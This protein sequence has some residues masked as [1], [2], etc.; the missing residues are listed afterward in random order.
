MSLLLR[1][2]KILNTVLIGARVKSEPDGL[3]QWN[4]FIFSYMI[5]LLLV[6]V[7]VAGLFALFGV[8]QPFTAP[9]ATPA[10]QLVIATTN[11]VT[12]VLTYIASLS[13]H[14]NEAAIERLHAA[15]TKAEYWL[16]LGALAVAVLFVATLLF[17]SRS[18]ELLIA[19]ACINAMPLHFMWSQRILN[20]TRVTER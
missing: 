15:R 19:A 2:S 14:M 8:Y 3:A 17:L 18:F 6:F 9:L 13:W 7:A 4:S 16:V 5:N 11:L 20:S 10:L 1:T 12:F